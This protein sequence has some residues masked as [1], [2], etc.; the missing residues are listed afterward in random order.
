MSQDDLAAATGIGR[1]TINGYCTGRLLLGERNAEK[2]AAVLDLSPVWFSPALPRQSEID[3]IRK[4]AEA[5]LREIES[6]A[7]GS[8]VS[9]P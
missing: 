4:L 1:G 5:L 9:E 3:R 7:G 2:I 8:Q 6:L